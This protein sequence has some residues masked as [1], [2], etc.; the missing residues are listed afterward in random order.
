MRASTNP[1]PGL[2]PIFESWSIVVYRTHPPTNQSNVWDS[3][4]LLQWDTISIM[5]LFSIAPCE[6]GCTWEGLELQKACDK[7]PSICCMPSLFTNKM[8]TCDR[9]HQSRLVAT[10]PLLSNCLFWWSVNICE[11]SS[12]ASRG[13][14]SK[15]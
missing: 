2:I 10:L 6:R 7:Q 15:P 8:L 14:L 9:N 11:C 12:T 1:L 3:T 4:S 13:S 5:E